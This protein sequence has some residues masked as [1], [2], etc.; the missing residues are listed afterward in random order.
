MYKGKEGWSWEV[1]NDVAGRALQ[2]LGGMGVIEEA[3]ATQ[4]YRD[5]RITT[6]YEGTTGIQAA[7]LV[8]RKLLG[9]AGGLDQK[10]RS[11]NV[12]GNWNSGIVADTRDGKRWRGGSMVV[13]WGS[14]ALVEAEKTF[15]RVHG[16]RNLKTLVTALSDLECNKNE[17]VSAE[18]I[19]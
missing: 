16:W 9:D 13:R 7:D 2:V 11:T 17:E 4:H 8:R 12:I 1:G 3:G 15:R 18:R 19:A 6:I 14:A 10:L 5:A